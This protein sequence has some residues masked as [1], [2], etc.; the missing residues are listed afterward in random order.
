M[1]YFAS[2]LETREKKREREIHEMKRERERRQIPQ[3]ENEIPLGK[4][5]HIDA[6]AAAKYKS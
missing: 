2:F 1:A 5:A 3:A 6:P 4:R